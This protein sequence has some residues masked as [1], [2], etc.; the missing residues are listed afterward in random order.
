MPDIDPR[1]GIDVE[2]RREAACETFIKGN[3]FLSKDLPAALGRHAATPR[4]TKTLGEKYLA[5][6]WPSTSTE[7]ATIAAWLL[8]S[9][10]KSK[11]VVVAWK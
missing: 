9:S 3:S 8:R 5:A 4:R 6:H 7:D 2:L 1:R 10:W 11:T